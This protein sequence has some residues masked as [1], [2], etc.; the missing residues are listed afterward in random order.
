MSDT[1]TLKKDM[2]WKA[3]TFILALVVIWMVALDGDSNSGKTV[4]N[5]PSNNVAAP[6]APSALD[7]DELVDDDAFLGDADAPVVIVEWSDYQ[8]PFCRRFWE[9]TLPELKSEYIDTGK[10]KLVYR[11]FPLGFHA[12]AKPAAQA[13]ECAREIGG[14]EAYFEMHDKIFEEQGKQGQGT[15]QFTA[16]D[17]KNWA[18]EIG[19]DVG[20][21]MDSGK[22]DNEI[23]DDLAAGS[24]AGITG[25][26][27]FIINGKL[28]S[29]AQP[30]SVFKQ[31]IDA[32]LA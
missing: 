22:F 27:G 19:Y 30:F 12:G 5:V 1:I 28:V 13:A 24:T 20:E 3:S 25:T 16:D 7:M 29:G 21:C 31:V 9:Q 23:N 17:V 10:V 32:E 6:S 2:L 18:T 14:D 4:N 15:V 26:P 8:C 11:E